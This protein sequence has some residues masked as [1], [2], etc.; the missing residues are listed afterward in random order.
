MLR[1][2]VKKTRLFLGLGP[3]VWVGGGSKVLNF[4]VKRHILLFSLQTSQIVLKHTIPKWGGYICPFHDS[5]RPQRFS[6]VRDR[7]KK[8]LFL[9][10]CPK[11][12]W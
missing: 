2:G 4:L 6:T 3:K 11:R 10:L 8:R 5:L 7:Q 1:E 12:G 9:G